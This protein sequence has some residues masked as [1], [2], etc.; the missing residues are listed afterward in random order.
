[1]SSFLSK[2]KVIIKVTLPSPFSFPPSPIEKNRK[3]MIRLLKPQSRFI[4]L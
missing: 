1:V 4:S 3:K 2:Q